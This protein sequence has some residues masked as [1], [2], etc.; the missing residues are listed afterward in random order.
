MTQ[1]WGSPGHRT[2]SS[3][4]RKSRA[5]RDGLV[6]LPSLHL[7]PQVL[8]GSPP[9]PAHLGN[10]AFEYFEYFEARWPSHVCGFCSITSASILRIPTVFCWNHRA[11]PAL[12][13][14]HDHLCSWIVT[15]KSHHHENWSHLTSGILILNWAL[16]LPGDPSM[17]LRPALSHSRKQLFP[18]LSTVFS[19]W[20]PPLDSPHSQLKKKK[21]KHF[22]EILEASKWAPRQPQNFLFLCSSFSPDTPCC[23][24]IFLA[25][26]MQA[27]ASHLWEVEASAT[28][29]GQIRESLR[30]F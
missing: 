25:A 30:C 19:P 12:D 29:E 21:N 3:K 8:S 23:W 1:D 14:F 17:V 26:P 9:D 2:F 20:S 13:K 10:C 5:N 18:G 4:V 27:W 16:Q 22:L 11:K 6:T 28:E 15:E 24:M 7:T